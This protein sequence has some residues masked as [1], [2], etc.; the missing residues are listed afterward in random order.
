VQ[1][2]SQHH[3]PYRFIQQLP[4]PKQPWNSISMD[5]IEQL[6]ASLG[7][8]ARLVVVC[9]LT[10]QSIFIPMY[11]TITLADLAKLFVLNVFSKHRVLSHV[12]SNHGSKFV[13]HFFWSLSK[14]LNMTLH[15]ILRY[16]PEGDGQTKCVHQT[17]EQY[18]Q[19]YCNY[20]QDNWSDL[21]PLAKLEKI[22][23]VFY[24]GLNNS[25]LL[26]NTGSSV[27]GRLRCVACQAS[28]CRAAGSADAREFGSVMGTIHESA[29]QG[30]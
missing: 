9:H 25:V 5:F 8:T 1:S 14:A 2:K 3:Q 12:M 16:H 27:S 17:V 28:G 10:K 13:S 22:N 30:F 11:N 6:P 19:V 18:L 26:N 23:C 21:L 29:V 15:L 7:F 4:V 24:V 20:Q